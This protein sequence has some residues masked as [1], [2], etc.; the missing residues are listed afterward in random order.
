MY[1][2]WVSDSQEIIND[3]SYLSVL[4]TFP[5]KV[6]KDVTNV[7][8]TQFNKDLCGN[9]ECKILTTSR[10]VDWAMEVICYGLALPVT[11]KDSLLSCVSIYSVWLSALVK[12]KLSIPKPVLREPEVYARKIFQHLR[13]LFAPRPDDANDPILVHFQAGLCEKI[14]NDML[15]ILCEAKKLTRQTWNDSLKYLLWITDCLLAPPLRIGSLGEMLSRNLLSTLFR[16]WL[17]ACSDSFPEPP[18]W[19]ALNDMCKRWRHHDV[20]IK[21]WNELSLTLTL[22]LDVLLHGKFS[23]KRSSNFESDYYTIIRRLSK[24]ESIQSWFRFL[25]IIGNPVELSSYEIIARTPKLMEEVY[26]SELPLDFSQ[27]GGLNKLPLIFLIVMQGLSNIVNIFLR[28]ESR[29]ICQLHNFIV[30]TTPG[31][32]TRINA[33]PS[34]KDIIRISDPTE[35]NEL[36]NPGNLTS[37]SDSLVASFNTNTIVHLLGQW[38]FEASQIKILA[39]A[40]EFEAGKAE[41]CGALCRLFSTERCDKTYR[42]DYL[43][44]FYNTVKLGLQINEVTKG[45]TM[46]NIILNSAN[47]FRCDLKGVLILLPHYIQALEKILPYKEPKI[48]A[49][50]PKGELRRSA[51]HILLSITSFPFHFYDLPIYDSSQGDTNKQMEVTVSSFRLRIVNLMLQ[52]LQTETDSINTQMLLGGFLLLTEDTV[53]HC[54]RWNNTKFD[55]NQFAKTQ[56]SDDVNSTGSL[57]FGG[58]DSVDSD[59]ASLSTTSSNAPLTSRRS[60]SILAESSLKLRSNTRVESI[61]SIP[62]PVELVFPKR[63]IPPEYDHPI[64]LYYLC[65][66]L[67][68]ERLGPLWKGDFSVTLM[69]L[70]VLSNFAH[71]PITADAL[72]SKTVIDRLCQYIESQIRRPP[73]YQ[74]RDLHSM[75]VASFSCL[76]SWISCHNQLMEDKECLKTVLAVVEQGIAGIVAEEELSHAGQDILKGN[77]MRKPASGRVREAAESVFFYLLN[78]LNAFP[79]PCGPSTTSSLLSEEN[80]LDFVNNL[81]QTK[82]TKSASEINVNKDDIKYYALHKNTI[83]GLLEVNFE[84]DGVPPTVIIIVRNAT[85]KYAW[86]TQLRHLAFEDSR[87]AASNLRYISRP[88]PMDSLGS[89]DTIQHSYFPSDIERAPKTD[90]SNSIPPLETVAD[91]KTAPN[92]ARFKKLLFDQ[93]E[94]EEDY[95]DKILQT[96]N[97]IPYPKD[98]IEA[99]QPKPQKYFKAGRML[100]TQLGFLNLDILQANPDK[101]LESDESLKSLVQLNASDDYNRELQILDSLPCRIHEVVY[102]LYVKSGQKNLGDIVRNMDNMNDLNKDFIKF[103][104]SLGWSMDQN[105]YPNWRIDVYSKKPFSRQCSLSD[106][107]S[108]YKEEIET[109]D[110]TDNAKETS[111]FKKLSRNSMFYYG[112]AISEIAIVLVGANI[113]PKF[114]AVDMS[115]VELGHASK[116]LIEMAPLAEIES[117]TPLKKRRPVLSR[118]T[119]RG[120]LNRPNA[121]SQVTDHETII[122]WLEKF[123]DYLTYPIEETLRELGIASHQA[124]GTRRGSSSNMNN[125]GVEWETTI[126]FVYP[127]QNGL[128]RIHLTLTS[129]SKGGIAG[130]LIHGMAVSKNVLGKL[131][132]QTIHNI[133]N[134][135]RLEVESASSPFLIRRNK[136]QEI[137]KKH[138]TKGPVP[139]YTFHIVSVVY[140]TSLCGTC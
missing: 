69:A 15:T 109:S 30:M 21:Q 25:H 132:R 93:A 13:N 70:D 26:K 62:E 107:R 120:K 118:D 37:H 110:M 1:N 41:A 28:C 78:H 99:K 90:C 116:K 121:T 98:N 87:L 137:V 35:G 8:V 9:V 88:S 4:H 119:S 46:A 82:G 52:A 67:I 29:S 117:L 113:C 40:K 97:D 85:G 91:A 77:K 129:V 86:T 57:N 125:K 84:D 47:L 16:V 61:S 44:R 20:L 48:E 114:R 81:Q 63:I 53:S 10:Q 135:Q 100:L 14:L 33:L 45:Q 7:L 3:T 43:S 42:I 55:L 102:T 31:F 36:P 111:D 49:N 50:V 71:V 56:V 75:I 80:I 92:Q 108:L 124:D 126:I 38:L 51:I 130:P 104:H 122:V 76:L 123:E 134:R 65:V 138:Q 39:E 34:N 23:H 60:A 94:I 68:G 89:P 6:S 128:Y 79:S 27:V 54:D 19:K 2:G 66:L 58:T 73:R 24:N 131:T 106:E 112:D 17:L 140:Y 96:D 103:V 139:T 115:S 105:T 11:E 136:I 5:L 74:S 64:S 133:A 101:F 18:L 127:L 83:I 22:H 12:P 72:S 32:P 59:T 95:I